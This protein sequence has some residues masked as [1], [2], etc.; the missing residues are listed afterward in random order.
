MS[1]NPFRDE[2]PVWNSSDSNSEQEY[3]HIPTSPTEVEVTIRRIGYTWV[4]GYDSDPVYGQV[5]YKKKIKVRVW[6]SRKWRNRHLEQFIRDRIPPLD[7]ISHTDYGYVAT[8]IVSVVD[9]IDIYSS[10]NMK[11]DSDSDSDSDTKSNT[12][13]SDF[14][15]EFKLVSTPDIDIKGDISGDDLVRKRPGSWDFLN[16]DSSE[17][18]SA[19]IAE[20]QTLRT[21]VK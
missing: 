19:V 1:S 15:S 2:Y 11:T 16:N 20:M 21:S 10:T 5:D 3:V 9:D 13:V 17:W 18:M 8:D 14:V 7:T 6:H 4:A 12:S